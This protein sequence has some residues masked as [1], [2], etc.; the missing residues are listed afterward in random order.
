LEAGPTDPGI[1]K[2]SGVSG[3]QRPLTGLYDAKLLVQTSKDGTWVDISMDTADRQVLVDKDTMIE[4]HLALLPNFQLAGPDRL[5]EPHTNE[6]LSESS[7]MAQ[8]RAYLSDHGCEMEAY[9]G[10][11]CNGTDREP[12]K[13][14]AALHDE[15]YPGVTSS[16]SRLQACFLEVGRKGSL[17]DYLIHVFRHAAGC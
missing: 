13:R 10:Y 6:Y 7:I 4:V 15:Q 16:S 12:L 3:N 2:Q 17:V 11:C 8:R 5:L 1:D 9:E 14:I